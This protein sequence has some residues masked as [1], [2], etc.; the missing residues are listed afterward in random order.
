MRQVGRIRPTRG[1]VPMKTLGI[2][3]ATVTACTWI[4]SIWWYDFTHLAGPPASLVALTATSTC[5]LVG[6][7]YAYAVF[8][9]RR[10][11][12]E[13]KRRFEELR[14]RQEREAQERERDNH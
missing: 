5:L 7:F 3:L 9:D 1:T 2:V 13:A 10:E 14:R 11:R 4:T 6:W 8:G 12:R